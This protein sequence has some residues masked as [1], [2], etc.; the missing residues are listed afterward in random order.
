MFQAFVNTKRG[1]FHKLMLWMVFIKFIQRGSWE[2]YCWIWIFVVWPHSGLWRYSGSLWSL[3]PIRWKRIYCTLFNKHSNIFC[4]S[5]IKEEETWRAE[6]QTDRSVFL[7]RSLT[8][9][10]FQHQKPMMWHLRYEN[11]SLI[12]C[13]CHVKHGNE[14]IYKSKAFLSLSTGPSPIFSPDHA[15]DDCSLPYMHTGWRIQRQEYVNSSSIWGR[16]PANKN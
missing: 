2:K 13:M 4:L 12:I 3:G 7:Y 9:A 1:C 6:L 11:P 16:T 8:S 14:L 5:L 10:Y 15:S